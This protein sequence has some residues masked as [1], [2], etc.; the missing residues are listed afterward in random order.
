MFVL[1]KTTYLKNS[2]EIFKIVE[3]FKKV[4]TFRWHFI[5]KINIFFKIDPTGVI[6][7]YNP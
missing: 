3:I 1:K 4:P 5:S 2:I 7:A 6:V